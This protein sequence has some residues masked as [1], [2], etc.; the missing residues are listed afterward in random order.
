MDPPGKADYLTPAMR[1]RSRATDGS[2]VAQRTLLAPLAL[3]AALL[4]AGLPGCGGAAGGR[5]GAGGSEHYTRALALERELLRKHPDA[6]YGD[7]A[8]LHVLREL[9]R[10]PHTAAEHGKAETLAARIMDGRRFAVMKAIPQVDHLPRRLRGREEPHPPRAGE[11][12][13]EKPESRANSMSFD[14]DPGDSS[15]SFLAGV[16][17]AKLDVTLYGTAWCGYCK[18]ARAWFKANG[19]PF[20][21]LDIEKDEH[22]NAAYKKAAGG[23]R[24][25]PLIV[26]NGKS[27]RGFDERAVRGL[28]GKVTR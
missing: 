24:G 12:R 1:E 5:A 20:H 10:V 28:I 21:D 14:K 15:P 23:Y 16:E 3:V 13:V 6:S 4:A 11:R 9:R 8:Y 19:I 25:V 26:V 22:A 7:A 17:E 27:I 2:G 18:K